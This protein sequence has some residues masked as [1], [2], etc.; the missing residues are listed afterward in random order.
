MIFSSEWPSN[1]SSTSQVKGY[2]D[3]PGIKGGSIFFDTHKK[4]FYHFSNN[5]W[6]CSDYQYSNTDNPKHKRSVNKKCEV[7]RGGKHDYQEVPLESIEFHAFDWWCKLRILEHHPEETI[8]QSVDYVVANWPRKPAPLPTDKFQIS[9][10]SWRHS[11]ADSLASLTT[12]KRA[13]VS[14]TAHPL[15]RK[16]ESIG[17][18]VHSSSSTGAGTRRCSRYLP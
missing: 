4:H 8:N 14:Y 10:K 18:E 2:L 16:R 11:E 7:E 3:F 5:K 6:E 15:K 13:G 1:D 9:S 12:A 17:G